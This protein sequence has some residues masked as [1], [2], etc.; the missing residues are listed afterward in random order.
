MIYIINNY[1][2]LLKAKATVRLNLL[3]CI[4]YLLFM[5][6]R[7]LILQGFFSVVKHPQNQQNPNFLWSE[8]WTWLFLIFFFQIKKE[9]LYIHD[10]NIYVQRFIICR[11]LLNYWV[12]SPRHLYCLKTITLLLFAFCGWPA[13]LCELII[14]KRTMRRVMVAASRWNINDQ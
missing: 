8:I 4:K 6:Q 11:H 14:F 12:E 5:W 13:E 3:F 2:S 1:S 10:R 7:Y 9:P